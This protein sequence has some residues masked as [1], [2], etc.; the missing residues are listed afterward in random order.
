VAAVGKKRRVVVRVPYFTAAIRSVA[1]TELVATV[2]ERIARAYAVDPRIRIIA[3]PP[4]MSGFAYM[5]AWHPRVTADAAYTWLRETM[6]YVGRSLGKARA[7]ERR[8]RA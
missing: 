1:E 5:M 6:R 8:S 2:P 3:P 7:P 4:E